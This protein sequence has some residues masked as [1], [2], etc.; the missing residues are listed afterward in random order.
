MPLIKMV[1]LSRQYRNLKPEIDAALQRV[2]ESAEF[3]MGRAVREFETALA[4]YL[5]VKHVIGCASGTDALQAALMALNIGPGDEVLTTPFTFVATVE[6][7]V[8]LGARPVFVDIEPQTYNLDVNLIEQKITLR[9]KAIIPV[10]LY[11]HPADL[12]PL[13]SIA[14]KHNLK[15]IEDTAQAIG[16]K[17]RGKFAGSW[18]VM[19]CLSFFPS[20]NLGAYGDG[21]ALIT[22]EDT[23]AEQLRMLINHGSKS[24]YHHEILGINSRLDSLQAA[25]LNVK[26]QHLEEWT[27]AR[28]EIAARYTAGLEG[29]PLILPQCAP[30]A[31][32]VYNQYSIRTP[33]RDALADF[34]QGQGISTAV[35]YPKPLHLQPAYRELIVDGEQFP[36]AEQVSREIL[37]LPI[38]PEMEEAEV[39]FVI[40]AIRE[41]FK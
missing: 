26:L 15:I 27:N 20:K 19:G 1:D 23:L 33:R 21:G 24:R 9:T 25:V 11:G 8:L 7:I 37:S 30:E 40:A 10:H 39:D 6:T 16:A 28:S 31:R 22:N 14:K 12:D 35:H 4:R 36:L 34:L 38:F 13:V 41:F 29:T 5:E 18:G 3:I 17:Y 32:H 2:L